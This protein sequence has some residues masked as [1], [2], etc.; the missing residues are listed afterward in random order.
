MSFF[1]R[2]KLFRPKKFKKYNPRKRS[3]SNCATYGGGDVGNLRHPEGDFKYDDIPKTC[4][5]PKDYTSSDE[6]STRF[7]KITTSENNNIFEIC[8]KIS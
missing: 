6:E 2:P 1:D 5:I 4:P 7:T 3:N 8:C